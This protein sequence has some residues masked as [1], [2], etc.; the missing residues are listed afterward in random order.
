MNVDVGVGECGH[1]RRSLT[2]SRPPRFPS[3]VDT[4]I[5]S[6]HLSLPPGTIRGDGRSCRPDVATGRRVCSASRPPCLNFGNIHNAV[7]TLRL[8]QWGQP[9]RG[10]HGDVRRFQRAGRFQRRQQRECW[11]WRH[12]GWRHRSHAREAV[13]APERLAHR[14]SFN[15]ANTVGAI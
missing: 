13:V 3:E 10:R 7:A 12:I 15:T 9:C 11:Q 2:G 8:V 14:G 4:V 5:L 6:D 1:A